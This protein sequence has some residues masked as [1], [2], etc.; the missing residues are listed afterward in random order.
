MLKFLVL[1]SFIL[2]TVLS[3]QA[4]QCIKDTE[5]KQSI[6]LLEDTRGNGLGSGV[7]YDD[8]III[9]TYSNTKK[10]R[11]LQA[12]I[13]AYDRVESDLKVLYSAPSPDLAIIQ[14]ATAVSN[15]KPLTLARKVIRGESMKFAS[16][17]FG[18]R[19]RLGTANSKMNTHA[20]FT[21][22]TRLLYF[23]A[24][25][26]DWAFYGDNGGTFFNCLGEL[27]GIHFGPLHTGGKPD[28][29]YGVNMR[30]IE[31]ALN[32]AGIRARRQY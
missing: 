11:D 24:I 25:L 31:D 10:S 5:I 22:D 8:D 28:Y 15:T 4:A 1:T 19:K 20:R 9:T 32:A 17:P 12:Y 26:D 6:I 14:M 3:V 18:N 23:N 13:A 2:S 16:F 21:H 30:A 29:I 7:L 27:V